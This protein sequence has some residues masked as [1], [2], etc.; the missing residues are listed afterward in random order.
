MTFYLPWSDFILKKGWYN[1]F[2]REKSV[3]LKFGP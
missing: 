2:T 1:F 3:E